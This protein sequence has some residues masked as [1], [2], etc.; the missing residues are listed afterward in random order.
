MRILVPAGSWPKNANQKEADRW[1]RQA[2][3]DLRA[4]EIN[5]QAE[6]P[7]IAC[8][9]AHQ[10]AEEALKAHLHA[11]G[12]RVVIGTATRRLVGECAH[13]GR[14]FDALGDPCRHLDQY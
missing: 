7:E 1:L 13:H 11:Q 9:L 12:K 2:Q 4:A 14:A 10:T 6:F 3:H 8:F 5:R